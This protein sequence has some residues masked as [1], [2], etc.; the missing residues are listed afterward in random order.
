MRVFYSTDEILN[1]EDLLEPSVFK[2]STDINTVCAKKLYAVFYTTKNLVPIF[3]SEI[4]SS[5]TGRQLAPY[6]EVYVLHNM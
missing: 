1:L 5:Q 2:L 4:L 3:G 6:N